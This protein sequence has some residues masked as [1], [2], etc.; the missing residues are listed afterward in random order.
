VRTADNADIVDAL[1]ALHQAR[2]ARHKERKQQASAPA[3]PH[4]AEQT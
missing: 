3:E 4:A 1:I 2:L